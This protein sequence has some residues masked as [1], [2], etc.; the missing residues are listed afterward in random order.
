MFYA[1]QGSLGELN[2]WTR[3][4]GKK[5][6][7]ADF[8]YCSQ[9]HII[10]YSSVLRPLSGPGRSL[11]LIITGAAVEGNNQLIKLYFH[12]SKAVLV[13]SDI[14]PKKDGPLY[15]LRWIPG[16]WTGV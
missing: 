5:R 6:D 4:E 2:K 16:G 14:G 15:A 9:D 12:L 3:R 11:I 8:R 10:I 7:S 1:S 13:L